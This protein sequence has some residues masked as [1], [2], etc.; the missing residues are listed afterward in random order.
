MSEHLTT[1]CMSYDKA[2]AVIIERVLRFLE[3]LIYENLSN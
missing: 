3:F 1:K 2:I